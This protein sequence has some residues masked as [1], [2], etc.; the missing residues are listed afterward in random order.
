MGN[1]FFTK[2]STLDK[3]KEKQEEM[4]KKISELNKRGNPAKDKVK[5]KNEKSMKKVIKNS[6]DLY[7]RRQEI[8]DTLEGKEKTED[9]KSTDLSW[10]PFEE[11]KNEYDKNAGLEQSFDNNRKKSI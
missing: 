2:Y 5:E 11:L 8:I 3:A 9:K 7:K 10:L 4:N 6:E 1:K